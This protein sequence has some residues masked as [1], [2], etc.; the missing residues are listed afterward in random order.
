MKKILAIIILVT[1]SLSCSSDLDFNQV[2]DL[3]REPILVT[4][5]GAFDAPAALFTTGI[6]QSAVTTDFP[7]IN[8]FEDLYFKESLVKVEFF[9]EFNNTINRAFEIELIFLDGG[10]TEIDSIPF[11]VPSYSGVPNLVRKTETFEGADFELLKTATQ[12]TFVV[13]MLGSPLPIGSPGSLK[14]RSSATIY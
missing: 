11:D 4:N 13:K 2:N 7:I 9:F 3:K 14:L 10:G 1:L 12:I 6:T 8:I 5:L